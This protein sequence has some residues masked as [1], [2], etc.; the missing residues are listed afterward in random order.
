M[1]NSA[2]STRIHE[3]RTKRARLEDER[4]TVEA[5][6][7]D[8]AN[9][10]LGSL[11]GVHQRCANLER[12]IHN[13]DEEIKRLLDEDRDALRSGFAAGQ[14]ST[15]DA[16]DPGDFNVVRRRDPW[17]DTGAIRSRAIA[18]VEAS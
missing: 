14:F 2:N 18:A 1:A 3:L 17:A 11:E 12:G 10:A 15:E 9:D 6:F 5:R 13:V 4:A 8:S 16:C 7:Q